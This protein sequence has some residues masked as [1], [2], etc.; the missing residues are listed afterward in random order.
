MEKL[1][2][3]KDCV[4]FV[5]LKNGMHDSNGYQFAVNDSDGKLLL[6][7]KEHVSEIGNLIYE[8]FDERP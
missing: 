3:A 6:S 2:N 8:Y 7:E 5:A 1:W 4:V